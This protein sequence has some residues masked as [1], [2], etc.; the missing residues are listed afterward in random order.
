MF[1]S[2][3]QETVQVSA[4]KAESPEGYYEEAE[5]YDASVNGTQ[6]FT[7]VCDKS[8]KSEVSPLNSTFNFFC[9]K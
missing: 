7:F 3:V 1:P 6:F 5:P 8:L 4:V 9:I 2:Q